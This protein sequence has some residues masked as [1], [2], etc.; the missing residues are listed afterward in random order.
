MIICFSYSSSCFISE[1]SG[2]NDSQKGFPMISARK[3]IKTYIA[4]VNYF[5]ETN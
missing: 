3:G 1:P 5:F 2:S 4:P